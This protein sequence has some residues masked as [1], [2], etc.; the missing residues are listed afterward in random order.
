VLKK[1]AGTEKGTYLKVT[2]A[3]GRD[4]NGMPAGPISVVICAVN[5]SCKN[6]VTLPRDGD[7]VDM[8]NSSESTPAD[9]NGWIGYPNGDTLGFAAGN[10]NFANP[11]IDITNANGDQGLGGWVAPPPAGS[12]GEVI[13]G[14]CRPSPCPDV[15]T[16]GTFVKFNGRYYDFT[17]RR[18][19]DSSGYVTLGL[20]V[21]SRGFNDAEGT[22]GSGGVTHV[23][24]P[25]LPP[26]P[27]D[28]PNAMLQPPEGS[29]N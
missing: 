25:D 15:R 5:E 29:G 6:A 1:E 2:N 14:G 24:A 16:K 12:A 4:R 28:P 3:L 11:W 13:G 17:F 21:G 9:V 20:D 18:S 22:G 23:P 26:N 10:P 7:S 8:A 19:P 27:E